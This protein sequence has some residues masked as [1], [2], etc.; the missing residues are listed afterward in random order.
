MQFSSGLSSLLSVPEKQGPVL[1]PLNLSLALPV[2]QLSPS[3]VGARQ[4][5]V[6]LEYP[7]TIPAA[8]LRFT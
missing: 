2:P 1:L 6:P 4:A 8:S 3:Q 5:G 7:E